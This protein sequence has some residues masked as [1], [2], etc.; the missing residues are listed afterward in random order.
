MLDG[1]LDPTD[2]SKI[3][4]LAHVVWTVHRSASVLPKS[5]VEVVQCDYGVEIEAI[6]LEVEV[7]IFESGFSDKKVALLLLLSSYDIIF[8][9]IYICNKILFILYYSSY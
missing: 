9:V 1:M 2:L 4:N 8:H 5:L 7:F 3:T 6:N